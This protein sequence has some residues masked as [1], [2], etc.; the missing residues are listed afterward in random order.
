MVFI[1]YV[2]WRSGLCPKYMPDVSDVSK[3][4]ED[5][6]DI[7]RLRKESWYVFPKNWDIKYIIKLR[8]LF[9]ANGVF[10]HP[11]YSRYYQEWILRVADRNQRFMWNVKDVFDDASNFEKVK[12]SRQAQM[13]AYGN[14]IEK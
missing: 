8:R 9:R 4:A 11:H 6:R 1:K 5:V 14:K 10:L 2:L 12:K 3:A 7:Q 13:V